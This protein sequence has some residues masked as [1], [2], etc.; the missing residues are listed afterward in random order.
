MKSADFFVNLSLKIP[1]NLA[2]IFNLS[3]QKP[4]FNNYWEQII[5]A[6]A[7]IVSLTLFNLVWLGK[8]GGGGYYLDEYNNKYL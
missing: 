7:H 2:L 3:C 8:E 6:V 5:A 1:Q 4:Y